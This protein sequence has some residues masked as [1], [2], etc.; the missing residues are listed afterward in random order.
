MEPNIYGLSA[1]AINQL[2]MNQR[3]QSIVI[4]GES[5]AGKTEQT[6][7][8]MKFITSL[9]NNN[10]KQRMSINKRF[11][12][13]RTSIN[14]FIFDSGTESLENRILS[15]SPILEAFGNSKTVRNDNSSRFGKLVLLLFN[16]STNS[17]KGAII[18][19]YL[20]EKARVVDFNE[21][22]RNYHIFY[23][24]VRGSPECLTDRLGIS[25]DVSQYVY[26]KKGKH[27]DLKSMP[28]SEMFIE[29]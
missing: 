26:L 5:G 18:T 28:D 20:L 1:L 13:F 17:L 25:R 3:N 6:K 29:I 21:P 2:V 4:S 12:R 15:C 23:H 10:S 11:S 16:K 14:Q 27:S 9:T 19:N 7:M 22:E 8:S 24:L